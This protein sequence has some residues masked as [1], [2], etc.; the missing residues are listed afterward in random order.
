MA[1]SPGSSQPRW[2]Q[3]FPIRWDEDAYVTRRE[4]TKFLGLTSLAFVIGTSW[5]AGQRWF[6]RAKAR[7]SPPIRV[8]A[9]REIPV[10]GYRLFRYPSAADPCI[11]LR[12]DAEKLTAF[13]Q[14]CTHLN[15]PVHFQAETRRL[16]CPCHQGYFSS[17]DGQPLAGPPRRPLARFYVFVREGQVWVGTSDVEN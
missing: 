2:K 16:V 1:R 11:L 13:G 9:L 10:G 12:T 14:H 17:E 5:T 6:K 4:F 3:D 15:C 8:A 7:L